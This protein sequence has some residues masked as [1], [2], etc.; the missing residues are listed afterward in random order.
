M[1]AQLRDKLAKSSALDVAQD[2]QEA[3]KLAE[4][5]FYTSAFLR[6]WRV[7]EA[8]S[9]ELTIIHRALKE[10][11]EVSNKVLKAINKRKQ[12]STN[13]LGKEI[14]GIL[15]S[16]SREHFVS[17]SRNIDVAHIQNALDALRIQ[18]DQMKI[19][20]LLLARLPKD[21]SQFPDRNS[22]REIRNRLVHKNQS[23]TEQEYRQYLPY[24]EYYLTL[25]MGL[26][27]SQHGIAQ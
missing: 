7:V 11:D 12:E 24:F 14:V 16:A 5:G 19:K 10:A 3:D 25:L 21:K 13:S 4:Q 23:L 2:L 22:I 17:S 26:K 1:Q 8:I 6:R 18:A 15:Y 9:R 20:Y 27:S